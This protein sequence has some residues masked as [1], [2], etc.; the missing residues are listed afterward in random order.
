MF[1]GYD[2]RVRD[3]CNEAALPLHRRESRPVRS[4]TSRTPPGALVFMISETPA[5]RLPSVIVSTLL[6][7]PLHRIAQR[8]RIAS[9]KFAN[10]AVL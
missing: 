4:Q 6:I 5:S 9:K 2:I 8:Q 10:P 7:K 1:G 3:T